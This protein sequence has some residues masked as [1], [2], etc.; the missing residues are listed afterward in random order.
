M[1]VAARRRGCFSSCCRRGLASAAATT[2]PR[3]R[4]RRRRIGRRDTNLVDRVGH[5]R[6]RA[7]RPPGSPRRGRSSRGAHRVDTLAFVPACVA[8]EQP[9]LSWP[10]RA[11]CRACPGR[12]RRRG[13]ANPLPAL[14]A[15]REAAASAWRRRA[16][17]HR[18]LEKAASPMACAR[19]SGTCR[20][21]VDRPA[22]SSATSRR[23][24]PQQPP[25]VHRRAH[26]ARCFVARERENSSATVGWMPTVP[27]KS[28]YVAPLRM[29]TE[30]PT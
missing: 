18:L 24:G 16:R 8:L 9:V 20:S 11:P 26:A 4:T 27:R 25:S 23:A 1:R 15:E 19:R 28:L 22:V 5:L 6:P 30:R 21:A 12:M 2:T 29:A 14:A 7:R 13:R 10:R 3:R 17:G